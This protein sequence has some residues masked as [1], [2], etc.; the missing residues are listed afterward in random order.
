M[1][2]DK[3]QPYLFVSAGEQSNKFLTPE[4]SP[5][6]I[7]SFQA[8]RAQDLTGLRVQINP[9][10]SGTGEPSPTNIR[11]ISGRTGMTVTRANKNLAPNMAGQE[12]T[13]SNGITFTY[14]DDG[15]FTINGTATANA[16][17][18]AVDGVTTNLY[19]PHGTYKK[20]VILNG[21]VGVYV[22]YRRTSSNWTT[23]TGGGTSSPTFTIDEDFPIIIRV[24]VMGGTTI[25]DL[26]FEPYVYPDAVNDLTWVSPVK[27]N[28]SVTWETEAGTVYGGTLD[29][30]SGVLTVDRAIYTGTWAKH[31]S[32]NTV[33]N[34]P[35]PSTYNYRLAQY[36]NCYCN[37]LPA[38][39]RGTTLGALNNTTQFRASDR[40]Y[41]S[42]QNITKLA[43]FRAWVEANELQ[44]C[45]QLATPQTYRLTGAE[46][47]T[48]AGYNQIYSDAGPVI[49][50]QF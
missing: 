23:V 5:T 35:D 22:Q 1:A 21:D 8:Q 29:V 17:S 37:C 14:N 47:R 43:D 7:A 6:G 31:P 50:I 13:T 49:D 36:T 45:Y 40:I 18:R 27:T 48:L 32:Y 26:R 3:F 2:L 46:V 20:P 25:N 16:Y 34:T 11:P 24:A 15:S 30:V 44:L 19:L 4:I 9:I 12:S 28:Y 33:F 42:V 10:Q 38:Q 41:V 39:E